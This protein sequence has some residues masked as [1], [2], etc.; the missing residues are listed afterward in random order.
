MNNVSS[1]LKARLFHTIEADPTTGKPITGNATSLHYLAPFEADK[2][3]E[4][5]KPT[6]NGWSNYATWRVNLEIVDGMEW[7]NARF[8]S[9]SSLAENIKAFATDIVEGYGENTQGFAH[10]YAMA[11][12]NEVNWYEIAEGVASSYPNIIKN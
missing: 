11:F 4:E 8:S 6:Y 10:D 3:A 2:L 9:L 1:T 7:T 5:L 12:L